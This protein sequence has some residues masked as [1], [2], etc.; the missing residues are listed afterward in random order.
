MR[1]TTSVPRGEALDSRSDP[2]SLPL[3]AKKIDTHVAP[4]K[5][6][7]P[8]RKRSQFADM[9]VE[10]HSN[11]TLAAFIHRGAW[12]DLYVST[13]AL[14]DACDLHPSLVV[15]GSAKWLELLAPA[16]WPKVQEIWVCEDGWNAERFTLENG[17]WT[18]R[19]TSPLRKLLHRVH[20]TYNLRTESLRYGWAPLLAGVPNRHGSAPLPWGPLLFTHQAPWLGKNPRIHERDRLL[21]VIEAPD[22]I[23]SRHAE[24]KKVG[25]PAIKIADSANGEKIA[26]AKAGTYWLF[27]TTS[28]RRGK[29]WA[30]ERFKELI[31]LLH[32]K[33]ES[34]GLTWRLIGAPNETDWLNECRPEEFA[35]STYVVQPGKIA[36][37]CDVLAGAKFLVTNASSMQF[38][39]PGYGV[40][41]LNIAG[42]TDPV[43]WGPLGP[44]DEVIRGN[45]DPALDDK[46]FEQEIKAYESIPLERV[47]QKCLDALDEKR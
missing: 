19:G 13:A 32:P 44:R 18:T 12:G 41:T 15:V 1:F 47:L 38:L 31:R 37:L 9:T 40:R 43:F 16:T 22:R 20:T 26:G 46:I 4:F 29:N 25:L 8:M 17:K 27:N 33:L 5:T 28:S 2:F 14:K 34:A 23:G 39:A 21:Q 36:D 35:A 45:V 24:W 3:T 30:P 7:V 11:R 10:S 42:R 6:L